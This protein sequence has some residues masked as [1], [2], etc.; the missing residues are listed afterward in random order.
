ML[1]S[2]IYGI[3]RLDGAPVDPGDARALGLSAPAE[4]P[5]AAH[6][7]AVDSRAPAALHRIEDPRALTILAGDLEEPEEL[8]VR[9]RLA[10]TVPPALLARAA[11]SRFGD[12]LPGEMIGEWSL[13]HWD[14]AG[15]LTL[16]LSAARRDRL[17]FA[18]SGPRVAIAPDV[19]RMSRIPWIGNTLDEA[20]LLFGLGREALR[21]GIGDRTMIAGVRQL[22]PGGCVT[23]G[24]G[25]C[26]ARSAPVLVAQSR[27]TGSFDG[28]A[29][30]VEWLMRRIL[31]ARL[32]R[33]K[34][35]A[36]LLSGGLDSS[37]VAAFAA[38]VR[39]ADQ[40]LL[41]ITS[42][43]PPGSGLADERGFAEE[44]AR[45]LGL[46]SEHVSPP[47]EANIYRPSD[48]ILG[49][50]SRPP[51]S[52]RHCL[53]E[54]FQATARRLG[55]TTLFDGLFGEMTLTSPLLLTTILRRLRGGARRLRHG[56]LSPRP[57]LGGFHVRLSG[58][59]LA[60]LPE[61]V[62]VGLRPADTPARDRRPGDLW[63][64]MPGADKALLQANELYPGAVRME[65]P[66]RDLRLL[67]LFASFPAEF[68][69]HGGL[70]RAL[71]RHMLAGRLPDSIRLRKSGLPA[72]PDHYVR[73]QRQAPQARARVAEFRKA[74][75][76]E[77]LDLDWLDAALERIG[78]YGPANVI[79]ANEVQL[80]AIT[81]EFLLWWR[82][83]S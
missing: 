39:S 60:R 13:L 26:R 45:S 40:K 82:A 32:A 12:G 56:P 78:V 52:N 3:F 27:R 80:T 71:A 30:E 18:V 10:P 63:G 29:A 76:E 49:G 62:R 38:E 70:N 16:M 7:E 74:E 9:L 22:E 72:S 41:L 50:A 55:A 4:L 37:T 6:A 1:K 8:A 20:G 21:C 17:F 46:R 34:V 64:Y 24:P 31:R 51:L 58:Y 23:I 44:V 68:L 2:G 75:L 25:E 65:L 33:T 5:D 43:A 11:L 14:R 36:V 19:F 77:W 53:T 73:L 66:F 67:R 48:A 79:E 59:R 42:V 61:A 69:E 57:D 15:R 28:A 47:R 35:P 54:T 83:H 81:A